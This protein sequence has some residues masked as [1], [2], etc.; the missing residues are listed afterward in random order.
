MS[1]IASRAEALLGTW[2]MLSWYREFVDT[3]ER[4][5][6]LGPDPVGYITYGADVRMSV[7]VLKRDRQAPKRPVP[8][9]EEKQNLFD[10]MLAYAGPYTL[11]YEKVVHHVDASWNET[12][13]GTNQVRFYKLDGD[14]L[15]ISSA[16]AP[17]PYT[18]RQIIHRIVFQKWAMER[19]GRHTG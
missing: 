13:T 19:S 8:A 7:F 6:A 11:D 18:G 15:T 1:A 9:D 17:D 2:K 10:S 16:P 12:W 5:D 3:G 4:I 14:V